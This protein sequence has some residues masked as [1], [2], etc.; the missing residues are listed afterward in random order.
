MFFAG[1]SGCAKDP[2]SVID[3]DGNVYFANQ[4]IGTVYR[5]SKNSLENISDKGASSFFRNLFKDA[6]NGLEE[7]QAL[8]VVGGFDPVKKEYL[9]TTVG[10]SS[11][12]ATGIETVD[13]GVDIVAPGGDPGGGGGTGDDG[14]GNTGVVEFDNFNLASNYDLIFQIVQNGVEGFQQPPSLA[15][16]GQLTNGELLAVAEV[17][18]LAGPTAPGVISADLDLDGIVGVNDLLV[19]LQQFNFPAV[20]TAADPEEIAFEIDEEEADGG[21]E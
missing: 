21:V 20:D 12:E 1:Q 19:L 6:R 11:T 3:N 4:S 2:S 14:G 15:P 8:R 9:L 13:L 18:G 7:G 16:N 5:Y 17:L 10:V